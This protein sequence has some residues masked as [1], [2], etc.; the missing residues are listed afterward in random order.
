LNKEHDK[1]I[2]NLNDDIKREKDAS[3]E[4]EKQ[5]RKKIEEA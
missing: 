1:K 3:A 4:K 5:L 2:Q